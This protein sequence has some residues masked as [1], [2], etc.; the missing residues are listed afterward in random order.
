MHR[1]RD[2]TPFLLLIE[3]PPTFGRSLRS[4]HILRENC[5]LILG[6]VG[7]TDGVRGNGEAPSGDNDGSRGGLGFVV[8]LAVSGEGGLFGVGIGVGLGWVYRRGCRQLGCGLLAV[9][10]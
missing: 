4:F 9:V 6:V 1:F 10:Y 5:W 7:L 3:T 8:G 2:R